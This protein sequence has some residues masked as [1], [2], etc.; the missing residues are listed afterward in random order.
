MKSVLEIFEIEHIQINP[1]SPFSS[2]SV[3][4]SPQQARQTRFG[5]CLDFGFQYALI[6][7]NRSKNF[8]VEYWTLPGS[9]S[10]WRP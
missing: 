4:G 3:S 9:N 7:N 5:P 10:P 8:G 6:R 1:R 2:H